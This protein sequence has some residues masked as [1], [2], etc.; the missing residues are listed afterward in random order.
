VIETNSPTDCEQTTGCQELSRSLRSVASSLCGQLLLD[1]GVPNDAL[2][3]ERFMLGKNRMN[4]AEIL[5]LLKEMTEALRRSA[6]V[7]ADADPPEHTGNQGQDNRQRD[8]AEEIRRGEA[9]D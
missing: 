8:G 4:P 3:N 6:R 9:A 2:G 1:E 5:I 7:V